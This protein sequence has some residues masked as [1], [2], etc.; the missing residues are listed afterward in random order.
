MR[1]LSYQ[2]IEVVSGGII[3]DAIGPLQGIG[4]GLR[5]GSVIGI[6]TASYYAGYTVGSAIYETYTAIAY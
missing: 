1:E 6:L 2:E 5:L 3:I 4:A